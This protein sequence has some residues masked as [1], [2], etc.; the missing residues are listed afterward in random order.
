MS[1]ICIDDLLDVSTLT[2]T[3]TTANDVNEAGWEQTPTA[4]SL[5]G[6]TVESVQLLY[7]YNAAIKTKTSKVV[8]IHGESGTGKTALVE[9]LREKVCEGGAVYFCAGKFFQNPG[10]HTPYSAFMDAF[11]DLCDLIC[12]SHDFGEERMRIQRSIGADF[13]LLS[14]AISNLSAIILDGEHSEATQ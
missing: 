13:Y 11:S 2:G 8:F 5:C 9:S 12:Q 1:A 3:L 6:R 7:T 4:R 10:V 14:K